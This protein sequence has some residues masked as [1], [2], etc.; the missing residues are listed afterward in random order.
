V[1]TVPGMPIMDRN[2]GVGHLP[3]VDSGGASGISGSFFQLDD[4]G[5]VDT[6]VVATSGNGSHAWPTQR[7]ARE[8]GDGVV[9]HGS[10]AGSGAGPGHDM[11]IGTSSKRAGSDTFQFE[12]VYRARRDDIL[13][14]CRPMLFRILRQAREE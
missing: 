13:T 9:L 11:E 6:D 2:G 5:H 7:A 3:G 14:T 8:R 4:G 1:G 10:R 12:A